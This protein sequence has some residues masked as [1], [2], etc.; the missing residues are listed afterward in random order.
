MTRH[1]GAIRKGVIDLEGNILVQDLELKMDTRK[2]GTEV[3]HLFFTTKDGTQ[4][5]ISWRDCINPGEKSY[6]TKMKMAARFSIK[7]QMEE[8][9]ANHP[10]EKCSSDPCLYTDEDFGFHVDHVVHF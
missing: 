9:R 3:F 6:A 5:N 4:D 2:S 8:F 10:I 1:Q 7:D